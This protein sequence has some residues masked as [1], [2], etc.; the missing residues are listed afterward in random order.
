[1][2]DFLGNELKIGDRIVFI[3]K[4]GDSVRL[5]TGTVGE[6]R[7]NLMIPKCLLHGEPEHLFWKGVRAKSVMKL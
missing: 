6:I 4:I 3:M 5:N 2:K 7:G 1:M